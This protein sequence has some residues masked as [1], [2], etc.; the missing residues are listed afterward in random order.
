MT[1][2]I[3]SAPN[4]PYSGMLNRVVQTTMAI[5]DDKRVERRKG[6]PD[7]RDSSSDR[8]GDN[9]VVAEPEPRRKIEDRRRAVD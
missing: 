6:P 2:N 1:D 4:L 3:E 7:R 9:R 5:D 8:R